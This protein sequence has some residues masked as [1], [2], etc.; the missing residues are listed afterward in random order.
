[1]V[2]APQRVD[3]CYNQTSTLNLGVLWSGFHR[4]V[5]LAGTD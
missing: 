4:I 1:M 5:G 2:S 3:T